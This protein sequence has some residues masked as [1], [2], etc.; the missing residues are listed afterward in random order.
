MHW[1]RIMHMIFYILY[2]ILVAVIIWFLLYYSKVPAWVYTFYIV[3][4]LI[5]ISSV[6]IREFC[7]IRKASPLNLTLNASSFTPW[8]ISYVVLNIITILL[9]I[10]G[11]SFTI[12]YSTIPYWVWILLGF[13][14]IFIVMSIL[15]VAISPKTLLVSIFFTLI[16]LVSHI[17]AIVYLM[18]SASIPGWMWFLLLPAFICFFLSNLFE[19]LSKKVSIKKQTCVD[20]KNTCNTKEKLIVE[21][22]GDDKYEID[23]SENSDPD[24]VIIIS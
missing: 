18:F 8:L 14:T 9:V 12:Q 24:Q 10:V 1:T 5:L 4:I 19:H 21:T 20:P 17:I 6:F 22:M 11:V 3:T 23:S 15:L 7:L 2:L 13:G 16:G